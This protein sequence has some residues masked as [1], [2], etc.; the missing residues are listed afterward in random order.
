MLIYFKYTDNGIMMVG[1]NNIQ[2]GVPLYSLR[3]LTN[4]ELNYKDNIRG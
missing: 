1:N 2:K 3:G 4:N